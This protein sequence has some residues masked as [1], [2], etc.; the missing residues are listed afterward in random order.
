MRNKRRKLLELTSESDSDS[1]SECESKPGGSS[2]DEQLEDK[3]KIKDSSSLLKAQL[4][5]ESNEKNDIH[6][7]PEKGIPKPDGKKQHNHSALELNDRNS[8]PIPEKKKKIKHKT[9]IQ[10][11][12]EDF[13]KNVPK[14]SAIINYKGM[15]DVFLR[16]TCTIDYH[17]LGLWYYVRKI[18]HGFLFDESSEEAFEKT[19][20]E[21][22][23]KIDN[24]DWDLARE[25]WVKNIIKYDVSP[26]KRLKRFQISLFGSEFEFFIQFVLKYQKHELLQSCDQICSKNSQEII[27]KESEHIYFKKKNGNVILYSCYTD[28]CKECRKHIK[29]KIKFHDKTNFIYIQ[30]LK[31]DILIQEI[32]KEVKIDNQTFKFFYSTVHKPGHFL[33]IFDFKNNLYAVDDIS[34]RVKCLEPR[35][36]SYFRIPTS[37][38]FYY[39][40][41]N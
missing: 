25:L 38:S 37:I 16:D 9:V 21:V 3:S 17:L 31:D 13:I 11:N 34:Q 26:T 7:E 32:P 12:L 36:V 5:V 24:N 40:I 35:H 39:L 27:S 29:P 15:K 33:G 20:E 14:W 28:K 19:L 8:I 41:E 10:D 6:E 2:K 1:D 23:I 22:I 18:N 30:S 4:N